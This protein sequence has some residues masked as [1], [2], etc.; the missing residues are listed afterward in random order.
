MKS[1]LLV[2][3]GVCLPSHKINNF[4]LQYVKEMKMITKLFP[5][6]VAAIIL[7]GCSH[8][9]K[10]SHTPDDV[11]YSPP[12]GYVTA[13]EEDETYD[14]GSR[15]SRMSRYDYRWRTFNDD[16]DYRY[17][18]YRYGYH[19]GYYY[20]PYYCSFPV[21]TYQTAATLPKNSTPRM[22]NLSSYSYQQAPVNP[23]GNP[24]NSG[25][26]T[27]RSYNNSNNNAPRRS[28]IYPNQY[29]TESNN[30]RTYNPG[31]GSNN[32]SNSNSS[33]PVIRQSRGQ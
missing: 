11:Y 28:T 21:Y 2:L 29:N 31:G 27:Y 8:S 10:L 13:E 4:T 25:T 14:Y 30:T 1:N 9:V 12:R 5:I 20:N 24:A 7:S 19:Y 26:R 16:F 32:N 18:P 3:S 22:T 33:T 6:F 23:K 15:V 17:D